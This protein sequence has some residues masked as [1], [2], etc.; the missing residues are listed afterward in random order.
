MKFF[1]A[2][3]N[4]KTRKPNWTKG[5]KWVWFLVNSLFGIAIEEIEMAL[6]SYRP[7]ANF[8]NL[9][10]RKENAKYE[11]LT[12]EEKKI[13][14]KFFATQEKDDAFKLKMIHL[15]SSVQLTFYLTLLIFGLHDAPLLEN[16][17]NE[18]RLN[19]ASTKWIC[20]LIWFVVKTLLSGFSTFAPILTIMKKDS[21]KLSASAPSIARYACLTVNLLLD[22]CFAAG[23]TFLEGFIHGKSSS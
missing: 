20:G 13:V 2:V 7:T 19:L 11:D 3:V 6:R 8:F 18:S 16:N 4:L 21:Y 5:P 1:K 12:V 9:Q 23:I 15:E 10:K 17:Y 22:L 14:M